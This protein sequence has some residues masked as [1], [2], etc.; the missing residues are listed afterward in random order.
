M[1]TYISNLL[2]TTRIWNNFHQSKDWKAKL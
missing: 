1:K 2:N